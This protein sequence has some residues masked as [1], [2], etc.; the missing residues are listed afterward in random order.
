[1]HS[2]ILALLVS[3][4]CYS[5]G[6][7]TSTTSTG[8]KVSPAFIAVSRDVEK[9]FPMHT[10]VKLTCGNDVIYAQVEDRMHKKWT[11]RVDRFLPTKKQCRIFGIKKNCNLEM[12]K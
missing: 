5:Y 9:L 8:K 6:E 11:R 12:V 10:K 2:I 7:P 4:T 1:M 3:C